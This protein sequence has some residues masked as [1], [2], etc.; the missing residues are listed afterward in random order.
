MAIRAVR[1]RYPIAQEEFQRWVTLNRNN[2]K[3]GNVHVSQVSDNLSIVHMIAQHGYGESSKP[4]LRY[5]ALIECLR[6]VKDI[7]IEH[8]SNIQ[9]PRIGTGYA[10]GNWPYV[11]ELI[12]EYLARTGLQITVYTLPSSQPVSETQGRL[13]LEFPR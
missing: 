4:R 13:G 7:A 9:M 12:D 6:K 1:E 3:L 2:L 11:L 8:H 10:G 5:D